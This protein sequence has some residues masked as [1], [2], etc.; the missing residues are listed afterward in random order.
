[1]DHLSA[2][3][4]AVV[5]CVSSV[6]TCAHTWLC[7][8]YGN[9]VHQPDFRGFTIKPTKVD[10]P[11]VDQAK[12]TPVK[13]RDQGP[14]RRTPSRRQTTLQLRGPETS[15]PEITDTISRKDTSE[16]RPSV[17]SGSSDEAPV[18]K[19]PN[20]RPRPKA[21]SAKTP[22]KVN[23]QEAGPQK[24]R[25]EQ[26][27]AEDDFFRKTTAPVQTPSATKTRSSSRQSGKFECKP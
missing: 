24:S 26:N 3:S 23:E 20:V 25:Q 19:T 2:T 5:R 7:F 8:I 9:S 14:P 27:R 21:R 17:A 15:I 1:M 22:S 6:V 12:G 16:P 4:K 10:E 18:K 11:K 13:N